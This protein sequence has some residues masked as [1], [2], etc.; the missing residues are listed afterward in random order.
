MPQAS[1]E[2]VNGAVSGPLAECLP[3]EIKWNRA[4]AEEKDEA[5][6]QHDR[7]VPTGRQTPW[8]D[9]LAV[10]VAPQVLVDGDCHEKAASHGLV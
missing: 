5:H 2:I 3:V 10:A 7:R 4:R 8:R 9:E 6:I 1:S